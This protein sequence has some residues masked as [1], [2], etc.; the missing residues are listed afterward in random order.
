MISLIA[1]VSKNLQIGLHNQ[2]PWHI[3]EDLKYFKQVTTGFP[4]IMGRKTFQSIGHPLPNRKNIILTRDTSFFHPEVE[5]LH[6]LE[7]ALQLCHTLPN[8]FIIGGGEI[9]KAFLPYADSLY[10]T[11]IDQIVEG[12]TSFPS[13]END[14]KCIQCTPLQTQ[15]SYDFNISF[16]IWTRKNK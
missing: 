7:E 4:V 8:I 3:P 6:S 1:A 11:L 15:S 16:T 5:V 9:Y 12:D 14:F 2:M 13:Y 10:L